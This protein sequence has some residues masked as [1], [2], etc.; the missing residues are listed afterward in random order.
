MIVVLALVA[1]F[2]RIERAVGEIKVAITH[3]QHEVVKPD[4]IQPRVFRVANLEF[5]LRA[6]ARALA[7]AV[8]CRSVA[9]TS[10]DEKKS[11]MRHALS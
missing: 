3:F 1:M 9:M 5:H 11:P 4:Q 7:S 10:S 6:A 2:D 8:R